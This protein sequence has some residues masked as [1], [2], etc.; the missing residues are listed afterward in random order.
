VGNPSAGKSPSLDTVA[1]PLAD[2]ETWLTA[3]FNRVLQRHEAEKLAAKLRRDAGE[4]EVQKALKKGGDPPAMLGN[5]SEPKP[6]ADH[7]P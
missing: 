2:L 5:A 7:V 3:D 4:E 1:G 6:R